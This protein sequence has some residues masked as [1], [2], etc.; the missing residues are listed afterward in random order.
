[1]GRNSREGGKSFHRSLLEGGLGVLSSRVLGFVREFLTAYFFGASQATDAFFIAWKIPNLFRRVLGE[2]AFDRVL[3]AYLREGFNREFLQKVLFWSVFTSFLVA[4]FLAITAP[5]AVDLIYPNGAEEV[6]ERAVSFLRIMVFYLPLITITSFFAALFQ[7]FQRYLWSFL[8]QAVFNIGAISFLLLFEGALGIYALVWSIIFG[9]LLQV[10]YI[11]ILSKRLRIL[12][13]PK[14]GFHKKLVEYF[15]NLLPSFWSV[16]IGQ[17]ST[18]LEAFFASF[19]GAG[20]L[21]HL[22]YAFRLYYLPVSVVAIV[23]SRVNFSS[24]VRSKDK[25]EIFEHLKRAVEALIY[26]LVPITLITLVVGES[27]VKILYQHGAFSHADTQKVAL[28]LKIYI[29]GLLGFSLYQL[30]LNLYHLQKRFFTAFFLSLPLVVV[31]ILVPLIGI[32]VF[33][34][35]GWVIALGTALGGWVGFLTLCGLNRLCPFLGKVFIGTTRRE[36]VKWMATL[37]S[38]IFVKA[39]V[40]WNLLHFSFAALWGLYYLYNFKKKSF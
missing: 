22:Y 23:G 7:Y 37:G 12:I 28:Y 36:F 39:T 29:C 30:L 34:T 16:G 19:A 18:L 6:K 35:G 14:F 38:L 24:L 26:L 27:A 2:G 4:V 11:L 33:H 3:L 17:I 10:A 8:S 31:E 1:M 20:T 25:G 5:F 32:F 9:G 21:S 40:S 15:R 13:P